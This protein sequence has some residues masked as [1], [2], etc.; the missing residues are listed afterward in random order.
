MK[1]PLFSFI[2]ILVLVTLLATGSVT[3]LADNTDYSVRLYAGCASFSLYVNDS[4]A[5]YSVGDNGTGQLGIGNTTSHFDP[6][7]VMDNV[8]GIAVGKDLF[9]FAIAQGKLYAWGKNQYCQLGLGGSYDSN[10]KTNYVATPTQVNVGFVPVKVVCGKSFALALDNNGNVWAV[11]SN[12][13]GQLA[14]DLSEGATAFSK[15]SVVSTFTKIDKLDDGVV[16]ICAGDLT[17]YALCADG[18]AYAWGSNYYGEFGATCDALDPNDGN[19][20]QVDID[21]NITEL[22]AYGNNAMAVTS[23]GKVYSWG[24]NLNKQLGVDITENKAITPQEVQTFVNAQGEPVTVT[25]KHVLCCGNC[26]F[27]IGTDCNLYAVGANSDYNCGIDNGQPPVTV[28]KFSQVT[29]YKPLDLQRLCNDGADEVVLSSTPVDK[30]TVE[31]VAV[32]IFVGG[33]G[34]RTFVRDSVGKTWSFGQNGN[35]QLCSGNTAS[36]SVPVL[37]T[38]FRVQSY[39][40]EYKQTDYLTGPIIFLCVVFAGIIVFIVLSEIKMNREKHGKFYL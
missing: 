29:F 23:S 30:S 8:S 4:G 6:Q 5:L 7:F 36:A 39:D 33:C 25:A 9:C 1:K 24:R 32:D 18:K 3:A 37:S 16:D 34:S 2:L 40:G 19:L 27:V 35:S 13:Y 21:E 38:L 31:Q 22:S 17:G 11:G 10:D 28:D 15:N 14:S 20:Y 12:R 26:N